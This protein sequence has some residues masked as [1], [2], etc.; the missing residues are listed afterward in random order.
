MGKGSSTMCLVA[1]LSVPN[2][3]T[4]TLKTERLPNLGTYVRWGVARYNLWVMCHCHPT[5]CAF[6]LGSANALRSTGPRYPASL[7]N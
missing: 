2:C 6:R 4:V 5:R 1:W 3:T 7:A